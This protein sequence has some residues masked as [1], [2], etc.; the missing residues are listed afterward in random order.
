MKGVAAC[1]KYSLLAVSVKFY[2]IINIK[3]LQRKTSE[4]YLPS[5]MVAMLATL[6]Y[7]RYYDIAPGY[8]WWDYICL[9]YETDCVKYKLSK[10]QT[11]QFLP[12]ECSHIVIEKRL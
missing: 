9:E 2:I 8:F 11:F 4:Y 5:N 6:P 7:S 12:S 10:H 1:N 3:K